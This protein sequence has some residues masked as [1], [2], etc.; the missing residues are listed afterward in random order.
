MLQKLPDNDKERRDELK[1]KIKALQLEIDEKQKVISE[2]KNAEKAH[3]QRFLDRQRLTRL[4]KQARKQNL[5]SELLKIALDQVYVAHHPSDI[6]YMPLFR[7]GQ[8]VVDTS[9]HLYRRAVTRRRILKELIENKQTCSWI[10]KDQYE[11]LPK[12]QWTIQDEERVFGGSITRQ[13]MKEIKEKRQTTKEDSRF[14]L[15]P[16]HNLVLQAAELVNAD[17]DE[18][19]S[20]ASD[21]DSDTERLKIAASK[22]KE[23]KSGKTK[24]KDDVDSDD[25]SDDS[26]S[27]DSDSDDSDSDEVDPMNRLEQRQSELEKTTKRNI[28]QRFGAVS[29]S[30]DTSS[31]EDD[32]TSEKEEKKKANPV[33]DNGSVSSSDESSDEE[34]EK[35]K[36]KAKLDEVKNPKE[37][38]EEVDDFLMDAKEEEEENIFSMTL[39]QIPALGDARGDKSKGWETQRQRPGQF[40][41][42]RVRR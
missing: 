9:R 18:E 4:D 30:S 3:G 35:Q 10:S 1:A 22:K 26:D 37:A 17:M 25:S 19:Q 8:R 16:E 33:E 2:K 39:K 32:E 41:K 7:K 14:A 42:R 31:D 27:D 23:A 6:K 40:K 29:G 13:G 21:S 5:D 20:D 24:A 15:A 28:T 38:D 11:R 36:L 12:E 34:E